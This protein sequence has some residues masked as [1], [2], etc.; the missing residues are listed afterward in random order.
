MGFPEGWGPFLQWGPFIASEFFMY[1]LLSCFL[2]GRFL[3]DSQ[4]PGNN[5][6]PLTRWG[7]YS[8]S[9]RFGGGG[10]GCDPPVFIISCFLG[11]GQPFPHSG[12]IHGKPSF[13][14]WRA[15]S[16]H[17]FF[18]FLPSKIL[19]LFSFLLLSSAGLWLLFVP[20]P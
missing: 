16:V 6:G 3:P 7:D 11:L 8:S 12:A 14:L 15:K 18:C 13:L 9:W 4:N 17:S 5:C 20:L 2:P 10:L 19:W 1:F